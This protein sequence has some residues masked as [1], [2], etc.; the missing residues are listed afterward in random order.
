MRKVLLLFDKC[1]H[2]NNLVEKIAEIIQEKLKSGIPPHEICVLAPQWT[3]LTSIVRKLK[4]HLPDIPL[5]AP[6]LTVLPRDRDNFWYKLTRIILS[7]RDPNRFLIRMKWAKE[8]LEELIAL[9]VMSINLDSDRC[10][11]FLKI[12]NS[13]DVKN[14]DAIGFLGEAFKQVFVRLEIDYSLNKLLIE[15]WDSFFFRN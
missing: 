1:T 12:V 15:Q 3:F 2:K 5:D 13:L 14:Q 10:R 6:G 8:I 11:K 9:D 7:P 4:S